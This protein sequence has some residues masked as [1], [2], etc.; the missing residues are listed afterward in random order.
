MAGQP[1][2]FSEEVI[3]LKSGKYSLASEGVALRILGLSGS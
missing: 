3:K 1:E 2:C